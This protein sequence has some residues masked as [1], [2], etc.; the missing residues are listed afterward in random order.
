M[1]TLRTIVANMDFA[2]GFSPFAFPIPD[3]PTP[4][5]P[6]AKPGKLAIG[7]AT[8]EIVD[9]TVIADITM[10]DDHWRT[11]VGFTPCLC[12]TV[13]EMTTEKGQR[14]KILKAEIDYLFFATENV[15]RRIAVV[16]SEAIAQGSPSVTP[17]RS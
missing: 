9:T 8:F 10:P 6:S 11:V 3:K 12:C 16:T 5:L 14:P 2:G 13:M 15:D 17:Q 4:V 1:I 7:T